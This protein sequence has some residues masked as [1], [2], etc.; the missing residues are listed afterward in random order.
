MTGTPGLLPALYDILDFLSQIKDSDDDSK[1]WG[2]IADKLCVALDAEAATY[3]SYL[4]AKRQLLPRYSLG[5]ASQDLRG[6]A[7]DLRTGLCGWTALHREPLIVN[8]A[9]KDP[10]FLKE[11]DALTGFKTTTVLA[12]P[13]IDRLDLL[14]VLEIINKRGGEFST[15]DL[16]F[17]QAACRAAVT[18]LRAAWLEARVDRMAAKNASIIENLGGG[19]LAVDAK[20]CVM[21]CNPSARRILGLS[22]EMPLHLPVEEAVGHVPKITEILLETLAMRRTV[23][24]QEFK[25]VIG[26][27]ERLLGYST[28]LIQDPQGEMTGA[29]IT[30]QDI[31]DARR[32]S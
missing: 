29:G 20:G 24:R 14:G 19:F 1:I 17:A 26:G 32:H 13:L 25:A 16:K 7:V 3:Y 6:T 10:R 2:R 9:Y 15:E 22:P 31:T 18:S 30:F 12:L 11:V 5:V 28:I 21:L 23:A 8:D 4:P 27:R